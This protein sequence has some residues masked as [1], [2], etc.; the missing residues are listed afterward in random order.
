MFTAYRIRPVVEM[1]SADNELTYMPYAA[2]QY[3][4][5]VMPPLN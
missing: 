2:T 1:Q 3:N 5:I 4:V